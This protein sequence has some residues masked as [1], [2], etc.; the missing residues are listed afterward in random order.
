MVGLVEAAGAPKVP[1]CLRIFQQRVA[2]LNDPVR[3][4]AVEGATVVVTLTRE[5]DETMA[6]LAARAMRTREEATRLRSPTEK[7]GDLTTHLRDGLKWLL[8]R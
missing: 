4:D 7:L 2:A 1:S 8:K 6:P 3:H 5:F